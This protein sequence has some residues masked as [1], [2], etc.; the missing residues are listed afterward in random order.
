MIVSLN[1]GCLKGAFSILVRLFDNV[2][3]KTNVRNIFER[4]FRFCQAVVTRLEAV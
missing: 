3:L 1:P 4:V 2:V